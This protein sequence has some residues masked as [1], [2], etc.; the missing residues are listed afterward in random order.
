M[1]IHD[2]KLLLNPKNKNHHKKRDR[3]ISFDNIGIK[4]S[5]FNQGSN[6]NIEDDLQNYLLQSQC[7]V[8]SCTTT[9]PKKLATTLEFVP[10]GAMILFNKAN[11]DY[12]YKYC[13]FMNKRAFNIKTLMCK[14][15]GIS[16]DSSESDDDWV[17]CAYVNIDVSSKD[18][19][20]RWA[21]T[22]DNFLIFGSVDTRKVGEKIS[23]RFIPQ[24][25]W[26]GLFKKN[27]KNLAQNGFFIND[28]R[29]AE[30]YMNHWNSMF[31]MSEPI[32]Y[33]GGSCFCC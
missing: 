12:D 27:Y 30:A 15:Y 20:L 8:G 26:V 28:N 6:N 23:H 33:C 19:P 29:I 25:V 3:A 1:D 11:H 14:Q 17:D 4:L 24:S 21:D 10:Y 18:L 16:Y 9:L 31:V 13:K 32:K 2:K 22:I 7:V 5:F